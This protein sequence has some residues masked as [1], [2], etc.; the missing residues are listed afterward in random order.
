MI[1]DALRNN[2]VKLAGCSDLQNHS[3]VMDLMIFR[4]CGQIP[5]PMISS[6]VVAPHG[7]YAK[8]HSKVCD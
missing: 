2:V 8:V 3:A 6:F 1:D 5:H 4:C 7:F